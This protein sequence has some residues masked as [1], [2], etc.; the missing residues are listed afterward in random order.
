VVSFK[1]AYTLSK[2]ICERPDQVAKFEKSLAELTGEP[3]KVQF[4]LLEEETAGTEPGAPART[5]SP[6]QRLLEISRHPMI[7]RAAELFDAKPIRVDEP[8]EAE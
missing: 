5:V 4:V 8:P 7:R 2:S 6:Q 1:P 3:V